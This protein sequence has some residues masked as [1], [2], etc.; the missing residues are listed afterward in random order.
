MKYAGHLGWRHEGPLM[1]CRREGFELMNLGEEL[2]QPVHGCVH[3][4]SQRMGDPQQ[5]FLEG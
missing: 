5:F 4:I 1:P 2:S 3:E